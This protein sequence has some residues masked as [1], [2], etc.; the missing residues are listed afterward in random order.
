MCNIGERKTC[1]R[2]CEQ[3]KYRYHPSCSVYGVEARS[4]DTLAV[5][6]QNNSHDLFAGFFFLKF[7]RTIVSPD[8]LTVDATCGARYGLLVLK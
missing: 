3:K 4:D 5:N 6:D 8:E 2:L 7:D 1:D